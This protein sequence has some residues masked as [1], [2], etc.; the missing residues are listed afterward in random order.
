VEHPRAVNIRRAVTAKL[1][2]LVMICEVRL[3]PAKQCA[4]HTE[5]VADPPEQNAVADRIESS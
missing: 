5:L 4:R 2:V 1:D 3:Q